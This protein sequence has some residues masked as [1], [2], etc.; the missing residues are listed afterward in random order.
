[1][2]DTVAS[3][4]VNEGLRPCR[5]RAKHETDPLG[6]R[7]ATVGLTVRCSAADRCKVGQDELEGIGRR[8]TCPLSRGLRIRGQASSSADESG[9]KFL[10]VTDVGDVGLSL[11]GQP[12]AL[13][14]RVWLVRAIQV[15]IRSS[16]Q[17]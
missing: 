1:M 10:V 16:D 6:S 4:G 2:P 8:S 12:S 15:S 9:E 17:P 3:L 14:S 7:L 11:I 13:R 5:S